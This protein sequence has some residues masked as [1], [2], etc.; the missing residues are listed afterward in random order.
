MA[1][2]LLIQ[3]SDW[4]YILKHSETTQKKTK[5]FYYDKTMV[6]FCFVEEM[7]EAVAFLSQNGGQKWKIKW[8]FELNVWSV[9]KDLIIL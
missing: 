7:I 3:L 5:Q 4:F 2:I 6:Y 8:I 1:I 9:L